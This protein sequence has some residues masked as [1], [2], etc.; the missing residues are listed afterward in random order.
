MVKKVLESFPHQNKTTA[1]F[2]SAVG[3]QEVSCPL[4]KNTSFTELFSH[5]SDYEYDLP[6]DFFVSKCNGC[7]LII[8]N[9]RPAFSEINRYY[10]E[11]YEPFR[12][13]GSSLVR[14]VRYNVLVKSRIKR[15]L[16]LIGE[17][18]RVLDVGCSTGGLLLELKQYTNYELVG[19]EPVKE[20]AR[21][22]QEANLDVYDCTLEKASLEPESFDLIV[23]NHVLEHLPNPREISN[24]AFS[25]LKKGGYFVG[26]LPCA[27][28]A[29]RKI[30]GK[31]WQ[32]F[33]LPRHLTW[34]SKR[35]LKE[36]LLDI[37]FNEVSCT[38]QPQPGNWIKSTKNFLIAKNYPKVWRNF[39]NNHNFL[40]LA[41]SLPGSLLFMVFGSAPIQK[42]IARKP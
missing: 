25:L 21:I 10:T 30:F 17:N 12:E 15:Y 34:F 39:F 16:N 3:N 1:G 29:E 19:V 42:F 22:A 2:K 36:F 32:G 28:C 11:D 27:D 9:P 20:A 41:L 5:V 7:G 26:E 38:P 40:L 18:G 6:G 31:Y 23:M 24:V 8:Q 33:H 14:W 13:V 37:G 4:C 35:Q